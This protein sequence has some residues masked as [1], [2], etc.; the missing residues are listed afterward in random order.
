MLMEIAACVHDGWLIV[1]DY[2]NVSQEYMYYHFLAER[3]GL[4]S[5][6]NGSVFNNLK[7]DIVKAYPVIIPDEA[8]MASVTQIF[9]Q[10][11]RSIKHNAMEIVSLLDLQN[12]LLG[13]LASN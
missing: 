3:Q 4:V 5:S 10:L 1:D 9:S 12:N 6:S 13:Q 7:T 11:N 2:R 8:T